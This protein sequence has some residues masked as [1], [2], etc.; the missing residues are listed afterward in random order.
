MVADELLR[1]LDPLTQYSDL[2][3]NE[4]ML[5]QA[6]DSIAIGLD[7]D[8]KNFLSVGLDA[9]SQFIQ[10]EPPCHSKSP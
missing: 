2:L 3:K 8:N 7:L 4:D 6:L 10:A 9:A 5:V 1:N